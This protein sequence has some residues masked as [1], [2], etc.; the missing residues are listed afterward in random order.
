MP[1]SRYENAFYSKSS[2]SHC[3]CLAKMCNQTHLQTS[4]AHVEEPL[5]DISTTSVV[6]TSGSM[7]M[8]HPS[9]DM[10]LF[11][12]F[13]LAQICSTFPLMSSSAATGTC[14]RAS[15]SKAVYWRYCYQSQSFS[16]NICPPALCLR[17]TIMAMILLSKGN[18]DSCTSV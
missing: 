15:V 9:L 6:I 5:H 12:F 14:V 3:S 10:W 13:H 11:F 7:P 16:E 18:Y 4:W 2:S 1:L 17:H 8:T